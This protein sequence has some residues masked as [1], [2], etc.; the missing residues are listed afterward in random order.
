MIKI[1]FKTFGC[2]SVLCFSLM[3][4][5]YLAAKT[6]PP[7]FK[8]RSEVRDYIYPT[9]REHLK[10]KF[11]YF[12]DDIQHGKN[13]RRFDVSELELN[14]YIYYLFNERLTIDGEPFVKNPY[15]FVDPGRFT[16]RADVPVENA[17]SLFS[18]LLAKK[19]LD[20]NVKTLAKAQ[21]S[22]FTLALTFV[23]RFYWVKDHPYFYLERVYAGV[24]PIPISVFLS[25]YQDQFNTM[26]WDFYEK[27]FAFFPAYIK[28]IEV[29][30][31][32]VRFDVE[33]KVTEIVSMS[34]MM[35]KWRKSNPDLV[36]ALESKNCL[37]GCTPK[38]WKALHEF[39]EN[40]YT[41]RADQINVSQIMV[42]QAITTA[43]DKRARE[44]REKDIREYMKGPAR[45]PD[46]V[47]YPDQMQ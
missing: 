40:L 1:G 42:G 44:K 21:H 25:D 26:I 28:K 16:L 39:N 10:N 12:Q 35:L 18:N 14:A 27:N 36:N 41:A 8:V 46:R 45:L 29:R 15:L 32:M 30:D 19:T 24:M 37:F 5:V 38:E 3:I 31:K 22:R 13:I 20:E 17:L 9:A 23:I 43:M 33:A 47:I 6:M 2:L 7:V 4:G 34:R 11:Y